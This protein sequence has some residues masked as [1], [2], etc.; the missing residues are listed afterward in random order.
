MAEQ[1]ITLLPETER[2]LA[3]IGIDNAA[4]VQFRRAAA[5]GTTVGLGGA[6]VTLAF[7][8][9][10]TLPTAWPVIGNLIHLVLQ[11]DPVFL[12]G[13]TAASAVVSAYLVKNFYFSPRDAD[14]VR[15]QF[16]GLDRYL[17]PGPG[18]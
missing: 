14:Y 5:I 1:E 17:P 9:E 11:L 8:P 6:S 15:A 18:S 10:S 7:V 16:S 3:S 13:V 4:L 12:I 2:Q